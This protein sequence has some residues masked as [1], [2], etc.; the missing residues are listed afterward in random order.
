V[1]TKTRAR[2]WVSVREAATL[3]DA[4]E[5]VVY[6]AIYAGKLPAYRVSGRLRIARAEVAAFVKPVGGGAK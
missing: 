4:S 1:S 5:Q 6:R 2:E 3:V